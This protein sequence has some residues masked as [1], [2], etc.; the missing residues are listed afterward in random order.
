MVPAGFMTHVEL[1]QAGLYVLTPE[2]EIVPHCYHEFKLKTH[3]FPVKCRTDICGHAY[4]CFS[5]KLDRTEKSIE[6]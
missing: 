3:W 1:H 4:S 2:C 6:Y 5:H